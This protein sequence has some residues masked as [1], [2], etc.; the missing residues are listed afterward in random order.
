MGC[1]GPNG[2]IYNPCDPCDDRQW[3]IDR[4]DTTRN[5]IIQ[6]ETALG[7]I[8]DGAQ[9]YQLDTGQTRQLVT[10]ANLGSV[11]LTLMRLEARLAT[12]QNR[13]GCARVYVRPGW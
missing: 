13:L 1:V 8:A 5:L 2:P 6:Y 7:A 4:I 9:S 10:K 11:Q 3:I 12:L